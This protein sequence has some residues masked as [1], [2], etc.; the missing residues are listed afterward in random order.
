MRSASILITG[1]ACL[2]FSAEAA[3]DGLEKPLTFDQIVDRAVIQENNLLAR[4]HTERPIAETYI[5]EMQ[6]DADFGAVPKSDHYFL[7][8][9][10]LS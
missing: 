6:P 8:K 5:Q 3:P 7:G 2:A 9:V 4:L 10:V 1:L